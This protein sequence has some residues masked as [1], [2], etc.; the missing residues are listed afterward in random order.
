[1]PKRCFYSVVLPMVQPDCCAECPLLGLI[2]KGERLKGSKETHVC[3]GTYE[4]LSGR[5]TKVRA[6]GRDGNHPWRR[7]CDKKWGLWTTLPGRVFG[8]RSEYYLRYRLP[9]EQGRQMVIKFHG[10]AK[11]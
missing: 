10:N 9:V 2:P 11:N 6:S 3:L 1:M 8:Y 5:G 4:A 7:P